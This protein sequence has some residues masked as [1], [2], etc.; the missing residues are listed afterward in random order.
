MSSF[1]EDS[2]SHSVGIFRYCRAATRAEH[3][4]RFDLVASQPVQASKVEAGSGMATAKHVA[5]FPA[6]VETCCQCRICGESK[7]NPG[8]GNENPPVC[9]YASSLESSPSCDPNKANLAIQDCVQAW[10]GAI[11]NLQGARVDSMLNIKALGCF[12][13]ACRVMLLMITGSMH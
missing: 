3:K 8:F 10:N 6:V 1:Q 7:P 12:D 5:C 11:V 2:F 13:V 4:S 9:A